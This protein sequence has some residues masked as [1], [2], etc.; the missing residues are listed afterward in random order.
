MSK[1]KLVRL[2]IVFMMGSMSV[3]AI[4]LS[5]PQKEAQEADIPATELQKTNDSRYVTGLNA[6]NLTDREH[7]AEAIRNDHGALIKRLIQLAKEKVEPL[8]SSDPRFVEYPWHDSKHLSILLLGD[9]RAVESVHVLLDNLEYKNPKTIVV[10]E[11]LDKGGWYPAVESLSKIG[12]PAVE[13]TIKKLGSYEPKSKGSDL[14]C[15]VLKEI[16]GIKLARYRLQIEIEKT[17]DPTAKDRLTAA[18]P[19]FKTDQEKFAEERAQ[20]EKADQ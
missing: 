9:L 3:L 20:R 17:K 18:L 2:A 7:A 4:E 11:Q 5:A 19:Y 12:M 10:W 14:C 15:W 8:P 13:P 6:E 1:T 16:L